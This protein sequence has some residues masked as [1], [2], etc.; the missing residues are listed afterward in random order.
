MRIFNQFREELKDY[1][2]EFFKA[3]RET[4]LERISLYTGFVAILLFLFFY[5]KDYQPDF[6]KTLPRFAQ[7]IVRYISAAAV[8][9]L[10]FLNVFN[11]LKFLF[12]KKNLRK[13]ISSANYAAV[14]Y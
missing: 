13:S 1:I 12:L 2:S 8:F 4:W 7:R 14:P 11:L 3:D 5:W 10:V 6:V 9:I